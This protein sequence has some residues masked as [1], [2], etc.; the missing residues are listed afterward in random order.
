[1][2]HHFQL[3]LTE[4]VIEGGKGVWTISL[5]A[6]F[7]KKQNKRAAHHSIDRNSTRQHHTI[8]TGHTHTVLGSDTKCHEQK[9]ILKSELDAVKSA[10][11]CLLAFCRRHWLCK[12]PDSFVRSYAVFLN[13]F[14]SNF[15]SGRWGEYHEL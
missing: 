8:T 5:Q 1:M 14:Q 11:F 13:D 9:Q 12:C 3:F 10:F 2:I 7:K 4:F 6:N 15:G